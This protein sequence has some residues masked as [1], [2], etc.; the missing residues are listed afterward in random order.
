MRVRVARGRGCE[1]MSVCRGGGGD[2]SVCRGEGACISE[3]G[4]V[5]GGRVVGV[6]CQ[7]CT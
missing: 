2:V 6:C 3:G 1:C 7:I 4:G 5:R